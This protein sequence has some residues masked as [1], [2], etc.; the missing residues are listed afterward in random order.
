[1]TETAQAIAVTPERPAR[2]C[3]NPK[4]ERMAGG[5]TPWC[6][7][8]CEPDSRGYELGHTR[9]YEMWAAVGGKR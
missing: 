8:R 9:H 2:P 7:W 6:C 5:R 1:M 4:C 3:A